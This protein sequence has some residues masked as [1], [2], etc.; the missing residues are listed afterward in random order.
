MRLNMGWLFRLFV[1]SIIA[2]FVIGY[3]QAEELQFTMRP[4]TMYMDPTAEPQIIGGTL[5]DTADW[6]AT[7]VFNVIDNPCT[8]TA[9]GP[10]VILTAAHCITDGAKGLIKYGNFQTGVTCLKVSV[11]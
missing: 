6:P 11:F 8:S 4:V 9:I 2:W 10:K 1:G 3:A 5:S 7:F